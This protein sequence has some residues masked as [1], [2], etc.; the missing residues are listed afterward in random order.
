ME[1]DQRA[2]SLNWCNSHNPADDVVAYT[3][4][5]DC[6]TDVCSEQ[7]KLCQ[8]TSQHWKGRDAVGKNLVSVSGQGLVHPRHGDTDE[9]CKDTKVHCRRI[10]KFLV[11]AY[12][13][14]CAET[15]G[16]D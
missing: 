12:A 7:L 8:N 9:E 4:S 5:K 2:S 14:C 16:D 6:K 15:K 11:D 1:T 10:Y 3:S 13:D